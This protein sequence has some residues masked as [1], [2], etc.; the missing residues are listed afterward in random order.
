VILPKRT[1]ESSRS[2]WRLC[3]KLLRFAR[4][5]WRLIAL[6]L[7]A[8][9][10]FTAA[11]ARYLTLVKPFIKAMTSVGGPVDAAAARESTE[12]FVR[13]AWVLLILAPILA[14]SCYA[15]EYL[16]QRAAWAIVVGIR[17]AMCRALLPQ[18][19]S[20]FEDRR[21]GDFI[22]RIT[23]DVSVT[24]RALNF[25]V[26]DMYLQPLRFVAGAAV[27][28]YHSWQ[29]TLACAVGLPPLVFI[30][31][32]L[33]GRV[34]RARA[35]TQVRMAVLTDA[36]QQMFSGIRVVKAFRMEDAEE[37]EF[38]GANMRVFRRMMRVARARALSRA[39]VEG[40]HRFFLAAVGAGTAFLIVRRYWDITAEEFVGCIVCLAYMNGPIKKLT[41]AYNSLQEALA[42]TER[43]LDIIEH[44][45]AIQDAPDAVELPA[46][47]RGV[48]FRQ[49]SF[50]YDSEPVLQDVTF[51]SRKGETVAVVG[52]SGAGKST[53]VALIP[54]FYDATHG[55][56][57]IDGTDVRRI[58]RESLLAH[59][60]IVTQQTFLFNRT[61]GDNIRYG[62]RDA[63]Q[64]EIEQAA[65]AAN[66][67]DF[68][69]G[70]PEGYDTEVGEQ[71]V[72]LS[73]GQR[74]RIA[75]ARAL[76]KDPA[77]LILDEAMAGLDTES[78]SLVREALVRL[79]A[80]R[81]T[82]IITHDLATI[83][84]ADRILVMRDGRIVET[85]T[86]EQL[87]HGSGE[88]QALYER[89]FGDVV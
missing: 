3:V 41:K 51:E 44:R 67:H 4:P 71:A 28:V 82:F 12:A 19:L 89:K 58:K 85:G 45:P 53:L 52:R 20:Y 39:S 61:I 10:I 68:I 60:A 62:K 32:R 79:M 73:G 56:V 88:Y 55:R 65:R 46:V 30:L 18:S 74:Q 54:R 17:D 34:R 7:I 69:G 57:E 75:I 13:V 59:I 40:I 86:H 26:G 80:G 83:R 38:H 42:G 49:V 11:E 64:E 25:L 37:Q 6:A 78:E 87:M 14:V 36:L 72:K 15:Q 31:K 77:I 1:S 16:R 9:T 81:T 27:A 22:S 76:I 33:G 24:Q 8:M 5:H 84:R 50:Q 23:N 43:I 35:E 66:I 70:L 47:A 48:A 21:S 63:T 2:T 29:L